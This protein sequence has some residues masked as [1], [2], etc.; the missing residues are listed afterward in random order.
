M[1][2]VTFPLSP[3]TN[4][5]D[6][7]NLQK[8]LGL[9]L[10]RR[11][12]LRDDEGAR[13]EL[14][15][16][17]NREH[18]ET[19]FGDTTGKLVVIFQ[20]EWR[21]NSARGV[22]DSSTA[23]ALNE[24]LR[25]WGVLDQNGRATHVVTGQV[26][27]EDRAPLR[28]VRVRADYGMDGHAIRLG[29]D[30]TD[31]E[32]R[33]TIRYELL[34][35]RRGVD[36][37][38]SVLDADGRT[39]TSSGVVPAAKPLEIVDLTAPVA[40]TP[41]GRRLE[42][43]V[44]LD[45]GLPAEN[46]TLRLYRRDFGRDAT[47]LDETTT[48]A[49][50]RYSFAYDSAGRPVSL[51]VRAV[52]GA[53]KE[54]P[55]SKPVND[56]PG[57]TR[58]ALNLAAPAA[59]GPLAPEYQRLAQDVGRVVEMNRLAEAKESPDRQDLTVLNRATGWDARLLACA[60][61]AQ[62][63][64]GDADVGLPAEALYGVL[65]AGLPS[66]KLLLAD[67]GPDV[68]E[69]ALR[70]VRDAGI[71]ALDD[72][73]IRRFKQ[74]FVAFAD[75]VR[76]A[77]AVPGSRS[78]YADLL[79]AS[80]LGSEEQAKFATAYLAHRGTPAQLWESARTAGLDD[81]QVGKLQLQGKLAFL[82]GSSG[83][84]TARVQQRLDRKDPAQL[85]ERNF[86]FDRAASW[87]DE[88]HAVA[89][90]PADRRDHLTDDDK[91]QLDVLIPP[92][93]PGATV[94]AR[95][96]LWA[97][98]MARKVRLSY[99]TH[100]VARTIERDED[101]LFQLGTTR[102]TTVQLLRSA[103]SQ[104][105]RLGQTP[106]GTFFET[107]P[108]ARAGISD[109][110]LG[111]TLRN[112]AALQ[113]VYQITPTNEA[114]PVLW[115]LGMTSAYDVMAYGEREF[116]ELY[117][118]K[119][120]EL[121]KVAPSKAVTRLVYRKA[122]QVSSVTY[123]LFSVAQ[124]LDS[125]L[126]VFGLSAPAHVRE[127]ARNELIKHFPTMESLFGSMDFCECEHCRSVL[128]PAAYL[129]DLLQF[130]D[131]EPQVWGNFL[132]RWKDSHGGEDYA[133]KHKNPYDA[134]VQRR[135]DLPHIP[136]TCE[137]TNT[138]L[139]YIDL[140]NEILE[141]Y[142]AHDKLEAAAAHDTGKATTPE[143]LA[144]PQNIVREAYDRVR[145][146]RYPLT[147]PFDLWIETVRAFCDAFGAPLWRVLEVFRPSDQLFAP[148]QV[149]DRAAIFLESLRLSPAEVELFTAPDPVTKWFE[150]YGFA[151]AADATTGATDAATGQRVDLNS[152]KA[153]SRRL[154]VTH[155]E[156]A[157]L[158]GTAFV[159]P[160]LDRL[161]LLHKLGVGVGSVRFRRDPRNA[162]LYDGN[163]DLLDPS[164]SA[165]RRLA[166]D[167][168]TL[169]PADRVRFDALSQD[170]WQTINEIEAF[171]G[172]LLDF[173]AGHGL[174]LAE[175]KAEVK[176]ELDAIPFDQILVLAD[177][178]G[179]CDF[180]ATIFRYAD[181]RAADDIAFLRLNLFARLW[182]KLGWTIE[183]TDRALQA[184]VPANAPFEKATLGRR[185]LLTA[186]IYLSHLKT[187]ED[188]VRV[189]KHVRLKLTTLWANLPTTGK[190]SLYE[191]LFLNRAVLKNDDVFDNPLGQ[192]LSAPWIAA[193]ARQRWFEVQAGNVR[194][195]DRI[196]PA[197]FAGEPR[198]R[199]VHDPLGEVQHLA[200]RGVLTDAEKGAL[201]ALSP[202][203]RLAELL[204][205]AQT[206]GRQFALVKGHLLT[207]QGALGLTTDD[208]RRILED[209]GESLDTAALSLDHVS[210]LYRYGLLAKGLGLSVR[211]MI[212]LK[213][214]SG[215]DPF[216]P[217]DPDPLARLEQDHP[218]AR[219]LRFV[220]VA[221]QLGDSAFS[222]D[223]LEYLLRHRFDESGKYRT[224]PDGVLALLKTLAD[225]IR[226]I[227]SDNAIPA[228]PAA[229]GEGVLRQKLGLVL[230]P[231]VVERLLAMMNGTA[232]FTATRPAVT[233]ADRLH[234]EGFVGE[235]AF[236]D[237][238]YNAARQEQRLTYRGVLLDPAVKAALLARLPRPM[239]PNPHV[240]SAVLSD[241]LDDVE[242]QARAF[243]D[244]HL[245]KQA[246]DVEPATGFL[247]AADFAL[248]FAS[249]P[250]GMSE[251]QLQDRLR[252]QR[253]R[254]ASAFLPFLQDR[255]TRQFVIQTLTAHTAAD[256]ALV[257][258]L[259][260]DVRLLGL[261]PPGGGPARP[262]LAALSGV[263]ERGLSVD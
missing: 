259:L 47:R 65:R 84:L 240:P 26:R 88:I 111:P 143:L 206:L 212:A 70:T 55:L 208:I 45:H 11:A 124:K 104:G 89:G 220:E 57:Q 138:A 164:A 112:V 157:D 244:K 81:V 3:R 24:L 174:P 161:V 128:S 98:D 39:L 97:E 204:D 15:Q 64:S 58:A 117:A 145:E 216:R 155:Q 19:F 236:R 28:G 33:Y 99:P 18:A 52:D 198:I 154:G 207:L 218:F 173:S 223:D 35:D 56:L 234:A 62:R 14:A 110:D 1:N 83:Q 179:G 192:Y 199:I 191:Q 203:P 63:L 221:E 196:D 228:D 219:T 255:L 76:L 77:V 249:A 241:L 210:L 91:E 78:T 2:S 262:I 159:N 7:A 20:K 49:D 21:I 235:P 53:G 238:V 9:L 256:P 168:A 188:K 102:G 41:P 61:T 25:D 109:A 139:P 195:A 29:D 177:P 253:T 260:A 149:Y 237:L 103:T 34:P 92:A 114:M 113:R 222:V 182:R 215:L 172:R 239:P 166:K 93:F 94:E 16:A 38:V 37:R 231:D 257:E 176:A 12:V 32:G 134:L 101:D 132:A 71:V 129:V 50:G 227:R 13:G 214:L 136:L 171:E 153:L 72:P 59:L 162:A 263:A 251:T 217:L 67:V 22:V 258:S 6:V 190:K 105:F 75:R 96:D 248:L 187:L 144:E 126:P 233:P 211:E 163:Q 44:V 80:G 201:V 46:L 10:E 140:V 85:T 197:P 230:A 156:L 245:R 8:A 142:V 158:V 69:R 152:A 106:V 115:A 130:V 95:R 137:N 150:L 133:A 247:D 123:N 202:N 175:V 31:A 5:P 79:K 146:A 224:D 90:I 226:A 160:R 87:V 225:G 36:L 100:V 167:R 213:Q 60:A 66:D 68:A 186:L 151:S 170:D 165:G 108:G 242:R 42:G 141:Y 252:R 147:L 54:T 82:T 200:F 194:T 118:A 209:A 250:T 107:H 121:Y 232:E 189:G 148:A 122:T 246:P 131:A 43:R 119:H 125:E 17:L 51:E 181:G 86:D 74:Q 27:R 23:A 116:M 127:S 30:T 4:G 229:M 73:A 135:P 261:E 40:A 178:D 254:L 120:L 169:S 185:P 205:A 243:F 183:E 48:V 184:F 180:D 193:V